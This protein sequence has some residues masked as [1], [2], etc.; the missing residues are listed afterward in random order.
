MRSTQSFATPLIVGMILSVAALPVAH[1][2]RSRGWPRVVGAA[3]CILVLWVVLG[4]ILAGTVLAAVEMATLLPPYSSQ[5]AG[6]TARCTACSCRWGP[7]PEVASQASSSFDLKKILPLLGDLLLKGLNL[8]T[9]APFLFVTI[10]VVSIEAVAAPTRNVLLSS[11]RPLLATARG[12]FAKNTRSYFIIATTFGAIVAVIDGLVLWWLGIPLPFIWAIVAF[13]TNFI[14]SVGFVIGVIPPALLGL[15]GGGW[16]LMLAVVVI[17]AVVNVI[18]QVII[19]PRFVID[20]VSL[21]LLS[22]FFSLFLWT[23]VLGP[24]GAIDAI[25]VTLLMRA[26]FLDSDPEQSTLSSFT[27]RPAPEER[28]H[29]EPRVRRHL[30]RGAGTPPASTGSPQPTAPAQHTE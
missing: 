26:L 12:E 22:T 10:A 27:R 15:L 29:R 7:G 20:T 25:P 30:R 28:T 19:Q 14:P 8:V 2:A 18:V 11:R 5:L 9:V 21:S 3:L 4:F 16:S 1:W 23:F 13:T 6:L 24:M 17:Y